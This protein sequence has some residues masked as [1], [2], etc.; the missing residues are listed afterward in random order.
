V[1]QKPEL[2]DRQERFVREYLISGNASDAYRRAGY[3]AR[4]ADSAGPRLLGNVRIK[5]AIAKLTKKRLEKLDITADSVLARYRDIADADTTKLTGYHVGAC[6]YCWGEGHAYHWK[7]EREFNEAL[8]QA[9]I[10][11]PK[12]ATPEQEEVLLPKIDGGFGYRITA[13]PCPSC[14]ECA[15]LGVTYTRFADTST[16]TGAEKQ[17]YEAVEQTKDGIKFKL[18]DRDKARDMIAR[19][20]GLAT[21]K[22]EHGVN[23]ALAQL[24]AGAQGTALPIAPSP[25]SASPD[26]DDGDRDDE[27]EPA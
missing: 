27:D 10:K 25:Y 14:P 24:L 15:G 6:R 17:L 19:H 7:T 8:A 5:A 20:V 26:A 18:A 12:G 4:D 13:N 23:D 11:L 1:A 9:K 3:S 2:S 22:V 16:L 21:E